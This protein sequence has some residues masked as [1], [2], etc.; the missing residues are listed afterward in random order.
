LSALRPPVVRGRRVELRAAHEAL[1]LATIGF[2]V[3]HGLALLADPVLKPTIASLA[4]PGA[5]AYR[6]FA[7]ALGQLAAIGMTALALT[8][9][10]RRQL[11]A[12]R[13][14]SAHRFI[15]GFWVLAVWHG[16]LAGSDADRPWF[17]AAVLLPA[18]TAATLLYLRHA[19]PAAASA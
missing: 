16:L 4:I 5:S 9:Y 7:T 12:A 18:A 3:L 6:P 13:W 15:A 8:Y 17:L 1:A 10:V 19:R 11:G 2:I 14:R